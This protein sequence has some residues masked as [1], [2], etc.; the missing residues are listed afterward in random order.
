MNYFLNNRSEKYE[1]YLFIGTVL[2]SNITDYK[3][4]IS[5][6]NKIP[7]MDNELNILCLDYLQEA[8]KNTES[9]I[10]ITHHIICL[11]VL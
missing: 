10:I 1:S 2:W 11:L 4:T 8:I 5:N 3:Y 9:C 7:N 6:I